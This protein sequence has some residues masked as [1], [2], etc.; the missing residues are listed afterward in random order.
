MEISS[1]GI[2]E[3]IDQLPDADDP[4][5]FGMNI[6]AERLLLI[7][8]AE[9]IINSILSMEPVQATSSSIEF[10]CFFLFI[11]LFS[12]IKRVCILN[13]GEKNENEVVNDMCRE[14][15]KVLPERIQPVF[16]KGRH[17]SFKDA[18]GKL[19]EKLGN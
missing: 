1:S 19:K 11:Y 4:S 10:V 6:F 18:V 3:F 8:Q 12:F 15:L 17:L 5:I 16:A 9:H 13:R 7:R 14:L 2:L